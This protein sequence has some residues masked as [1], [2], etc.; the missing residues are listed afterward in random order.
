MQRKYKKGIRRYQRGRQ[1]STLNRLHKIPNLMYWFERNICLCLCCKLLASLALTYRYSI[2]ELSNFLK[3]LKLMIIFSLQ[4]LSIVSHCRMQS[5]GFFQIWEWNRHNSTWLEFCK[6]YLHKIF[7]PLN[8]GKI[9]SSLHKFFGRHHDF[10]YRYEKQ[11]KID[12]FQ[13]SWLQIRS[14]TGCDKH[15]L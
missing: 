5:S 4:D 14:Y 12:I 15:Q 8:Q 11:I 2:C 7:P 9:K 10:V 13:M 1:I 3:S 6:C